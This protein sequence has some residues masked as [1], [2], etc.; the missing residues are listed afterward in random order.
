[1]RLSDRFID[2]AL[3]G[4]FFLIGQIILLVVWNLVGWIHGVGVFL[5]QLPMPLQTPSNGVLTVLG[6][7]S[8]FFFGLLLDLLS[9]TFRGVE[10]RKFRGHLSRNKEWLQRL[11]TK[12]EYLA[13]G[14]KDFLGIDDLLDGTDKWDEQIRSPSMKAS[15]QAGMT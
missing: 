8:I 9:S 1:M 2:Y 13:Q 10:M 3:T 12:D 14:L 11:A 5:T 7:I 6:I 15:F 4:A